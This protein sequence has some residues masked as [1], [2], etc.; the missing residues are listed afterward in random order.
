MSFDGVHAIQIAGLFGV[1]EPRHEA[2]DVRRMDRLRRAAEGGRNENEGA[3]MGWMQKRGVECDPPTL[4]ASNKDRRRAVPDGVNHRQQ[5]RDGRKVFLFA[6]EVSAKTPPVI[7]DCLMAC[8]D[9]IQLRAPHAAV[10]DRGVQKRQ[11]GCLRPT[12]FTVSLAWPD[13]I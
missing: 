13:T 7:R 2:L 1:L 11:W 5:I 12:T 9:G 6:R 10:A 8:A 3:D 4:R